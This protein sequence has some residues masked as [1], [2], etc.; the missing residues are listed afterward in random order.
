[1]KE[2][3]KAMPNDFIVS[4]C[5]TPGVVCD[6]VED[7]YFYYWL[8]KKGY[9][10]FEAIDKIADFYHVD[11]KHIHYAGLKDEDGITEQPIC[12]DRQDAKKI[13]ID[14]FNARYHDTKCFLHLRYKGIY[15]SKIKIGELFGKG[16]NITIRNIS[17]EKIH[18]I[19]SDRKYMLY[20]LNYYDVQRFG[21]PGQKQYTHLIGQALLNKN[22]TL[23]MDL[24]RESGTPEG[25]LAQKHTGCVDD[26]FR[27][28]DKRKITFYLNSWESFQWNESLKETLFDIRNIKRRFNF[29]ILLVVMRLWH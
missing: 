14:A 5:L 22:M 16:F 23:A 7:G 11:S 20:Y 1:M 26:F 21:I 17:E 19:I 13:M 27:S 6:E 29:L 3:I 15:K 24:L 10:T 4:E 18:N 12:L 25:T 28:L 8:T 2:I 9:T